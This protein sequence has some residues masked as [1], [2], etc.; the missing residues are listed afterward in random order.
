MS[1]ASVQ[2]QVARNRAVCIQIVLRVRYALELRAVQ[3]KVKYL[4]SKLLKV[5]LFQ[6]PPPIVSSNNLK[7]YKSESFPRRLGRCGSSKAISKHRCSILASPANSKSKHSRNGKTNPDS[8]KY[9]IIFD[10]YYSYCKLDK[11]KCLV[12]DI[13]AKSCYYS[14]NFKCIV[15]HGDA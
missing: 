6:E 3:I 12:Q 7:I 8:E 15:Y 2:F 13:E 14:C 10:K 5:G 1:T 9:D 11:V 4:M